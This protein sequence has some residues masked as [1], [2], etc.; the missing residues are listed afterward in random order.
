MSYSSD[1]PLQ[2]N[3]LPIS[4]DFPEDQK[5]FRNEFI[6]WA[7]RVTDAVNRKEGSVFSLAESASFKQYPNA[8]NPQQYNNVYRKTFD[9][10]SLNGGAPIGPGATV[11]FP[12]GI[13]GMTQVAQSYVGCTDTSGEMFS[14]QY[15]DL[16]FNGNITF[17]NPFT[18]A[19]TKA[20]AVVDYLKN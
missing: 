16:R 18:F 3:Q 12:T 2:V 9:L 19:V 10:I 1:Q 17:T 13:N 4:M 14:V 11:T 15:P 20:I 5:E 6:L 7:K 8:N